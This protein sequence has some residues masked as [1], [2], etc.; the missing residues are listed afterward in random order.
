MTDCKI[1]RIRLRAVEQSY[2]SVVGD[3]CYPN[4]IQKRIRPRLDHDVELVDLNIKRFERHSDTFAVD[5]CNARAIVGGAENGELKRM[6]G[7]VNDL[8]PVPAL[9]VQP[10]VFES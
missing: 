6:S 9:R 7:L 8:S 5:M 4:A 3:P 1:W 2:V 10:R